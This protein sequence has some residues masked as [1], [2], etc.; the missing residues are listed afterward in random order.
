MGTT[1]DYLKAALRVLHPDKIKQAARK[2]ATQEFK[3]RQAV[4]I[5]RPSGQANNSSKAR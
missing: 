3:Q 1:S 2:E 4:A 5:A